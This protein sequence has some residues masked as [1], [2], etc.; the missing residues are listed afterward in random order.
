MNNTMKTDSIKTEDGGITFTWHSNKILDGVRIFQ[1]YGFCFNKD[2]K[3]ILTRDKDETRFTLPGGHVDEGES[4]VGALVR[5]FKEEAQFT[6]KNIELLGS[7][8]VLVKD[9]NLNIIDHH[10]QA[11]FICRIDNPGDFIPEKNGQ[12]TVERIFVDLK[13]LPK[14]LEWI[15]YPTGKAQ[16]E[17]LSKRLDKKSTTP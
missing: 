5:E 7:L 4:A 12:E 16:F 13:E 2:G 9:N 3:V 10:Q 14:Y 11:R 1:V 8:E 17:E 6:P 15:A